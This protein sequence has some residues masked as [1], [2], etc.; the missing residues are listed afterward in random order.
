MTAPGGAERPQAGEPPCGAMSPVL[1]ETVRVVH[2]L[3]VPMRD[4]VELSLDLVRPDLAGPLPVVLV[5]T[6]YDKVN[7]HRAGLF[8]RLARHG[9]IVALE[10]C[11]GRFNSDGVFQPYFHEADDGYDTVEWVAAQEWCDGRVGMLGG[12]YSAQAAWHA[13]SRRPPHL[14]AIVP[15]VS[16]PSS[17]WRNEPIFNGCLMLGIAEWMVGMGSRSWQI[18]EFMGGLFSEYQQYFDTLPV[19]ALPAAAGTH[20]AWWDEMMA[21][22]AYDDFWRQGSY[23]NHADMDVPAL[24]VTG[25]WDLNFPGAPSNFEAMQSSVAADKQKLVIGPWTHI[26]NSSR[27]LNGIDFGEH[28]VIALDD[29]IVRFLDR[30]VKGVQNGI[31]TEKP[32]YVFVIG[33]NEWWAEDQWPLPD[34]VDTPFYLHSGGNANTQA[35]DGSLSTAP[36]GAEPADGFSYDPD[37][38]VKVVWKI[39]DGPVDDAPVTAR[40]DC[41][42]YTSEPLTVPLDVVGWVTA[43]LYASSSALDTDWH[44]RLVDVHPD[45]TARF[46]CR[47]S[48]RARFRESVEKPELLE[49]G[50]PTC[51]EFTMDGCGIRFLP[52]HRIRVEV[53]SSWLTRYDRNTNSGAENFFAD[54]HVVV[55]EQ[56]IYHEPGLESCVLLPVVHRSS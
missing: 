48:L 39:Q 37:D 40:A 25:W 9:Y 43:R 19:A 27:E 45:G 15:V 17:L 7:S 41:L 16:P 6:P 26:A 4:G 30:W 35:G 32:V 24:N 8:A 5:R 22:P 56:Q 1:T 52:G 13:A 28:A 51:F 11:R 42:C 36:P 38:P 50:K 3:R 18:P 10:D 47:G 49:P 54:D 34:S 33:A 46:L 53:T 44:V 31:D 12:S 23:G 20:S 2:N 55:A 29:Y 21:H 14:A